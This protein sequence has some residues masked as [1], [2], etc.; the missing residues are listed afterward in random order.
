MASPCSSHD[1]YGE[2]FSGRGVAILASRSFENVWQ[3]GEKLGL[4]PAEHHYG[5]S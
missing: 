4:E 3:I 5:M 1:E 2:R